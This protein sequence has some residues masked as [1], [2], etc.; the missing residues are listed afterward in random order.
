MA[1]PGTVPISILSI[2]LLV[3]PGL[4]GLELYYRFSKKTE[5]L[6]RI[7]WIVYSSLLSISSLLLIYITTPHHFEFINSSSA[8]IVGAWNIATE[9]EISELSV[10]ALVSFY[11]LHIFAAGTAGLLI[12]IVDNKV[13]HRGESLDRREPWHYA[14]DLVPNDQEAVEVIMEDQTV[15]EGRYNEAAWDESRRELFLDDPYEIIYTSDGE[16]RLQEIDL[17]RSIILK[18]EAI[19]WVVFTKEDPDREKASEIDESRGDAHRG[20][21]P[22]QSSPGYE[23]EPWVQ[24]SLSEFSIDGEETISEEADKLLSDSAESGNSEDPDKI[25]TEES[26]EKEDS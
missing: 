19:S 1:N 14:F 24:S 16:R 26:E 4:L 7:Q 25:E 3:V 18:E 8:N 21:V 22:T 12:G 13:I 20:E 9:T 15:I 2:I 17:G 23:R 11:V 10:S 5:S 6:S